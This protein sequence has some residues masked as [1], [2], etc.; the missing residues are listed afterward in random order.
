M[1]GPETGQKQV[2]LLSIANGIYAGGNVYNA[3]QFND[4]PLSLIENAVGGSGNDT[5]LGNSANNVL[6]G[7]GGT[8]PFVRS[9]RIPSTLVGGIGGDELDGGAGFDYASY[10]AAGSSVLT[11]FGGACAEYRR[12]IQ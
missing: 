2:T 4:E 1:I 10:Q 11:S 3:L 12:G 9:R 5:I 7:N 6:S 8:R